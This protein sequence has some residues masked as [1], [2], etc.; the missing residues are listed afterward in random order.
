[1]RRLHLG[2]AGVGVAVVGLVGWWFLTPRALGLDKS[3]VVLVAGE[4]MV[5]DHRAHVTDVL[6]PGVTLKTGAFGGLCFSIHAARVCLGSNSE[7]RLTDLGKNAG[8]VE[9]KRGAVVI[10]A[11]TD[12]I[13]VTSADG[14]IDVHGATGALEEGTGDAVAR[15]LAGSV[16]VQ[17]PSRPAAALASPA[18]LGLRD[19]APRRSS[20]AL[21]REELNVT[22][23]ALRWQGSAGGILEVGGT[24]GRV[25]IDGD[26]L[27]RAPASVL[28]DEGEHTLVLHDGLREIL[29]ETIHMK[30]GQKVI[31]GE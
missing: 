16:S 26:D 15:S 14:A 10:S 22:K 6:S 24:R 7:A 3:R 13:R 2:I 30:G 29:R 21:E 18:A 23:V 27:G 12:D 9:A 5:D 11:D 19:G 31:R 8:T 28:L 4:A 1:M 20:P 25:E 17:V